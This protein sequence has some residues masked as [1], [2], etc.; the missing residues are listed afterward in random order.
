MRKALLAALTAVLGASL[1]VAGT[2]GGE[3]TT[4]AAIPGCAKD[5]LNLLN[6]ARLTVGADNPA[7][8]PWFGGK[9][10][11]PWKVS[12]PRSGQGYESAVAYAIARQLGFARG[13]V[14]WTYV[15]FTR[16]FRPGRKPFDFYIT[17]VSYTPERERVVDFSMAYYF[18]NQAVVGLQGRPITRVRTIAGLR[19]Y[20]LGAQLGTTSYTYITR[21]IR[22]SSSPRA[23]DT[24][25]LAIQALK[26][27]QIDGIV[28]DL[29][30]SFY[31]TA[32]QVPNS[33][34]VGQLPAKGT[35]ERFG[36]VFEQGNALR[37]CVN[38]AIS[39]LW[40]NGTIKALQRKWLARVAGARELK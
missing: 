14:T 8:P 27:R 1:V 5:G 38:R 40:R 4:A 6:E 25:D 20:R 19:P 17:Q 15:P 18:V 16:S 9:P 33:K 37:M 12:D 22:P 29:P 21:H 31:V 39:R 24:N 30:T 34:I 36:L 10:R 11:S 23:Y 7:F 32:V 35:K 13:E 3:R 2:A 26:N 28:V